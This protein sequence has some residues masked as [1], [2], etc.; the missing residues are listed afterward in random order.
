MV[1]VE[2]EAQGCGG[3]PLNAVCC[4]ATQAALAPVGVQAPCRH[5]AR[6]VVGR[7]GGV[8]WQAVEEALWVVML[9]LVEEVLTAGHLDLGLAT[10]VCGAVRCGVVL[11]S[12]F[13]A[14]SIA[15]ALS[16]PRDE[17]GLAT[18]AASHMWFGVRSQG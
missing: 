13:N 8:V 6:G 12:R 10:C 1:G 15:E 3:L 2:A 4:R 5:T 9:M 18:P 7:R 14:R 17:V 16:G 11:R